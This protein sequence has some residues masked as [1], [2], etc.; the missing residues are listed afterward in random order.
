M[1][2]ISAIRRSNPPRM[3]QAER[4]ALSDARMLKAA[5]ELIAERGTHNTTLREV[6]ERAGYSRGL[7]SNRFGSKEGLFSQLVLDFNRRWAEE[8]RRTVG[9]STGLP[10]LAAAL[11][12]VEFYLINRPAEMR[13]LYILWF[14]SMSS[15]DEV[16][17]RLALNHKAYRRDAERWVREGIQE[18]TIRN[19]V[20][21]KTF[22]VEFSSVIFGL[23]YQWLID[24]DSIDVPAVFQ[25]YQRNVVE[26]LAVG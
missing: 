8:L 2:E 23:I 20:D 11:R 9:D 17:Q 1:N 4:T 14:E 24:A 3:T 22:A 16:R 13:A 21:A 7:A 12:T 26:Q 19:T 15:H 5:Q 10:A 25:R 6:G 18:G